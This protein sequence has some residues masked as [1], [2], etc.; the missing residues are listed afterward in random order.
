MGV[1]LPLCYACFLVVCVISASPAASEQPQQLPPTSTPVPPCFYLQVCKYLSQCIASNAGEVACGLLLA[2][3][4]LHMVSPAQRYAPE[5]LAFL[6]DALW[7]FLGR[8]PAS[9]H[10]NA[11][12][13]RAKSS[14]SVPDVGTAAVLERESGSS[15]SRVVPGVLNPV[16]RGAALAAVKPQELQLLPWLERANSSAGASSSNSSSSGIRGGH[17]EDKHGGREDDGFKLGMMSTILKVGWACED[18]SRE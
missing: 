8:S 11:K 1:V 15:V 2:G 12:G 3:L 4:A 9:N 13:G 6:T 10:N 18:F 17:K 5:P 14:S 7:A 16:S